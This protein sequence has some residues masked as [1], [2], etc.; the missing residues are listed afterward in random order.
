MA[1]SI[2][3]ANVLQLKRKRVMQIQGFLKEVVF[4]YGVEAK[5]VIA[6]KIQRGKYFNAL[7]HIH[8]QL[9]CLD[10][11]LNKQGLSGKLR[12]VDCIKTDLAMAEQAVW[13]L[14]ED[15]LRTQM[16][17]CFDSDFTSNLLKSYLKYKSI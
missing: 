9:H 6:K 13:A 1:E 2:L 14:M 4:R 12:I 5:Q 8:L 11:D 17:V 3:K 15:T 16:K 7:E 10:V